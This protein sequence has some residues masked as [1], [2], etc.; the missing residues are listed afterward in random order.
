MMVEGTPPGP[1]P[2][3]EAFLEFCFMDRNVSWPAVPRRKGPERRGGGNADWQ[4]Q[5]RSFPSHP[6]VHLCLGWGPSPVH[7][8]PGRADEQ[9]WVGSV[10]EGGQVGRR[11]AAEQPWRG[12]GRACPSCIRR[13][14]ASLDWETPMEKAWRRKR[15]HPRRAAAWGKRL[16]KVPGFLLAPPAWLSAPCPAPVRELP[17]EG[18]EGPGVILFLARWLR[19]SECCSGRQPA[20][21][22]S[23]A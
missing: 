20:L 5:T 23:A 22:R 2:S 19:D 7:A 4:P 15:V 11:E 16:R 12:E 6:R 8:Y 3:P 17:S 21:E 1:S 9:N 10:E 13:R 18:S 14:E